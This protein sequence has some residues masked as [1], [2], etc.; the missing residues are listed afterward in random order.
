MRIWFIDQLAM[1][2]AY[3]R[4]RRNKITHFI[5]VPLI[6]FSLFIITWD[7]YLFDIGNTP[8]NLALLLTTIL[9]MLY[10][11]ISPTIGL[12]LT[13]DFGIGLW[14]ASL[15]VANESISAFYAFLI[16]FIVGWIIQ[17]VGHGYEGRK[18]A[19]FDN[20]LQIF[21]APFFLAAEVMFHYNVLGYLREEIEAQTHK[22]EK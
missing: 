6:I 7:V 20:L 5:G 22:Y 17:F 8:V 2:A 19:L 3:H 12:L 18:P 11:Y 21:M 13:I 15:V 16:S 1:Y 4:D 14:L 10:W 9:L